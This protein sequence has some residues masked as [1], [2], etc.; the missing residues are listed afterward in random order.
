MDFQKNPSLEY[1]Y[2]VRNNFVRKWKNKMYV[3]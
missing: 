3:Q 2:G 1:N